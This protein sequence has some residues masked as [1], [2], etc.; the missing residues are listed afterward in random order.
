MTLWVKDPTVLFTH[1]PF[2][3]RTKQD[4][5]NTLAQVVLLGGGAVSAA[6]R[7]LWPLILA[8]V[9]LLVNYLLF[10]P[11]KTKS[12]YTMASSGDYASAGSSFSSSFNPYDPTQRLP[13]VSAVGIGWQGGGCGAYGQQ[14]CG[15]AQGVV[16][17]AGNP[18]PPYAQHAQRPQA[19]PPVAGSWMATQLPCQCQ[20]NL[21]LLQTETSPTAWQSNVP[22]WGGF[23]SPQMA[24]YPNNPSKFDQPYAVRS[25]LPLSLAVTPD[26]SLAQMFHEPETYMHDRQITPIADPTLMARQPVCMQSSYITSNEMRDHGKTGWIR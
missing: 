6:K 21:N 23:P 3:D 2:D 16:P 26:S 5:E 24:M 9:F 12:Y 10:A 4:R 20:T 8:L 15:N 25:R 13:R 7:T 22:V 17:C 11:Y 18:A 14:S 19:W 1:N